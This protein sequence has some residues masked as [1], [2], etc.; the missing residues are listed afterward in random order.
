MGARIVRILELYPFGLELVLHPD[1]V[2]E[3]IRTFPNAMV[4]D[5]LLGAEQERER[6]RL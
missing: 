1:R 2:N 4:D 3:Y 5:V 6:N